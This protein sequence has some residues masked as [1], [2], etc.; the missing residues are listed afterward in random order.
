MLEMGEPF[1]A[2]INLRSSLSSIDY[3]KNLPEITGDNYEGCSKC[4]KLHLGVGES[5]HFITTFKFSTQL[6]SKQ[7]DNDA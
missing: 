1:Q 3:R 7:V 4:S 5:K 6:T 2:C